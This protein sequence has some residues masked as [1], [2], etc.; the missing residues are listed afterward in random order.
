MRSTEVED[1]YAQLDQLFAAADK[2]KPSNEVRMAWWLALSDATL[3]EV[4]E[5]VQRWIRTATASTKFPRPAQMRNQLPAEEYRAQDDGR[6]RV[7]EEAAMKNWDRLKQTDPELFSLER[8]I[9]IADRI[10]AR[11]H[12]DTAEHKQA[13]RDWFDLK[14]QR[15]QLL[16][17]RH[18]QVVVNGY[19]RRLDTLP[20]YLKP[21]PAAQAS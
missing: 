1:F 13:A 20:D 17:R 21:Q 15:D 19:R 6:A 4:R 8:Q 5:N 14:R 11:H 2:P 16:E 12:S 10:M 3:A 7:A 18:P 9:A